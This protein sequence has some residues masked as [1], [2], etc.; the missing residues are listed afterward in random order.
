[1][2]APH[3]LLISMALLVAGLPRDDAL[4]PALDSL[5]AKDVLA[6]I[7]E[8]ASD[9]Y[10][11]RAP[12]TPGEAKTVEYL[13]RQLQKA[14]LRPGNPDGTFIQEVPLIGF[15]TKGE[16]TIRVDETVFPLRTT[17]EWVPVSRR[18]ATEV[19]VESSDVFFV[20]YGVVA[21]EY[22]WDD[23]KDVDVRG[24]T[25]I[26]LIN[27][28]AVPDPKDPEKLDESV[29]KGKA[30]TYYGR[31]TYKYEIASEKGAAAALIIHETGPA[32]YP[33]E[34]VA[35]SW[36]RENFDIPSADGNKGRVT[37]EGWLSNDTARN[38]L[39]TCGQDL[40]SLKKAAVRRDFRPV[41]LPAK[42]DL[43]ARNETREVKSKNVIG[44]LEGSDP[45]VKDEV[46]IYT[47]HWDH[48]GRDEALKGD[49]IFNG[50]ADNASG[51]ACVLE[52]ARAFTALKPAPR[53]SML[54]LF[55]T[56]E[57]KGLLGSKY[58]ATHPLY[59]LEK[60]LAV[61]NMDV[62]NAWGKT[63]DVVSVGFGNST[64]DDLFVEAARGQGRT[65]GP[66]AEPEKGM[67]YRSD[68]F[69]F[70][71]EGVPALNAKGGMSYVGKPSDYG[72]QK[73]D[74][75]TQKDYHKPTDEVK[76]DWDL[77][78]AIEDL[79]LLVEVGYKVAQ[80]DKFPEWMEGTE[81]KAR[82]EAAIRKAA[83]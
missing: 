7:E 67:F 34:V 48:L 9:A 83:R 43:L 51:V 61:I 47:A 76:P 16:G 72:K 45:K 17:S 33:Y 18:Q 79:K 35:G 41:R 58:Y 15:K 24:K 74:E 20:G 29:F 4:K 44:K 38:I 77:S 2:L 32:S 36:G 25:I 1:M 64:L 21:P 31:W 53:R 66:D 37:I 19:R 28:P 73:R 3:A 70:A 68:H 65:V 56:A 30:M 52:L 55:V 46:V 42:A 62:I 13:T 22:G 57:E 54:F 6:H 50:A 60:T 27:D 8:I 81:F 10:E 23:Y 11:G 63:T 12:G 5:N 26:M 40:D 78:G 39:K 82:R 59:P 14:G 75:Y 49:Q 71:K 69:E 80:G